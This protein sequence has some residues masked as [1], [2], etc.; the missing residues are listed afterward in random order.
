MQIK[1]GTLFKN[2]KS[3]GLFHRNEWKPRHVILTS[4]SLDFYDFEGGLFKDS[5]DLTRCLYWDAVEVMPNDCPKSGKSVCTGWQLAIQMPLER[6]FI[7][8]VSE[9]DMHAWRDAIAAVIKQNYIQRRCSTSARAGAKEKA[10]L[11]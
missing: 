10:F 5:I 8:A 11:A 2:D 9:S 6:H 1:S 7:A 4:V 3:H